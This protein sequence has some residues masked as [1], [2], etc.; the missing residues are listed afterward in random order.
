VVAPYLT[1]AALIAGLAGGWFV[2]DWR[3][4]AQELAAKEAQDKSLQAAATAIAKIDVKAVTINRKLQ[5]VVRENT[6]Y[7]DDC[8]ID[9]AGLQ[10]LQQAYGQEPAA[11][12]ELPAPG[13]A[14]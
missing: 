12:G 7:R 3:R 10:L 8:A 6:V 13:G 11:E 1:L 4:D 5:E 2:N 9:A 14:D